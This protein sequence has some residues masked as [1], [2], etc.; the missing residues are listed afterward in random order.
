MVLQSAPAKASV[1]GFA[2]K[3]AG[4]VEVSLKVSGILLGVERVMVAPDGTWQAFLPPTASG[5]TKHSVEATIPTGHRLVLEDILFGR[6][7]VCG[8]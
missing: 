5:A 2:P 4:S 6:V 8:G 7:W 1:W 3:D